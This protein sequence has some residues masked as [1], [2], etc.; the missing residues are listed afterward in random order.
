MN[1][2]EVCPATCWA[3]SPVWIRSA[4]ASFTPRPL[5]TRPL[6]EP[7][8]RPARDPAH[9]PVSPV[10]S[11][12]GN[13]SKV[14]TARCTSSP[15]DA[16]RDWATCAF[17]APLRGQPAQHIQALQAGRAGVARGLLV[18]EGAPPGFTHGM[19]RNMPNAASRIDHI[20]AGR[21]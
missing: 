4:N 17:G 12:A 14:S 21:K 15:R 13:C 9:W 18:Q 7:V 16:S 5:N 2:D 10:T 20:D 19:W 1:L 3:A 8:A 11:K 6:R